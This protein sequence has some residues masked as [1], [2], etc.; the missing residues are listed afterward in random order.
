MKTAKKLT[1][2]LLALAMIFALAACSGNDGDQETT[3]DAAVKATVNVATLMGPTGIGMTKLMDD[4]AKGDSANDYNFT[5]ATSPDQIVAAISNATEPLD[6]AACP[7][8]LA[9]T[10][11]KK[12]NGA[13]QIAAI[14]TLGVLYILE[15]GNT[16]NSISDLKGKTL[17]ATGQGSTPEYILNYILEANG[18]TPGE[19]VTINYVAE[20]AELATMIATGKVDLAMLP[21][22]NVTSARVQNSDLR[23]ALD[24]TEEWGKATALKGDGE[25]ELVQGCIIVRKDFAEKNPEALKAFLEEY[26][27]S[28]DYVNA[29]VEEASVLCETYGIIPKAAVAKM[30]IPN[31]NITFV[32]GDEMKALAQ[33]NLQ[34]L[35]DANPSS[36]GGAMPADDFYYGC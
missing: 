19:D 10:L 11:Y 22:P 26:K 18:L 4:D 20:H 33:S 2:L 3:G 1:A 32:E 36:I 23:I 7:I 13:I 24:V 29:N 31:C 5:V 27:S 8:N 17:Y 30:A 21:E 6:I 15:N 28:V 12:T 9:S 35:F 34:I 16:I 14:N 25:S